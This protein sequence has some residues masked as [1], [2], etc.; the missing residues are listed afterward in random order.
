MNEVSEELWQKGSKL[1]LNGTSL[2]S[3]GPRISV[4]GVAPKYLSKAVGSVFWSVDD[5]KYIDYGMAVGSVIL[6]H[7]VI[8]QDVFQLMSEYGPNATILNPLQVELAERLYKNIRGCEKMKFL[9]SGSEATESAVRMARIATGRDKI[10]HD[11]YHGWMS[12]SVPG[13][14]GVPKCYKDLS[15]QKEDED[16]EWFEKQ[17]KKEDVAGV[18]LEPVKIEVESMVDRAKYLKELK[19][20]CSKY[21]T[22]LIFDEVACGYR[23]GLGGAQGV[24]GVMPDISAFGKSI[25]NGY[26]LSVVCCTS[27][28]AEKVE[29]KLFVSSTF[30]GNP[31]ALSAGLI[32]M[33]W[34]EKYDVLQKIVDGGL[35]LKEIEKTLS[36][37]GVKI[38]GTPYRIGWK[39]DDWD[40]YSYIIQEFLRRKIFFG[41]EIKN[42]ATH[43]YEQHQLAI[44]TGIS[45]G[46]GVREAQRRN[47]NIK[48]LIRGKPIRPIL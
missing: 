38:L 17:L 7:G 28:I 31:L 8:D 25:S 40:L 36:L 4:D 12:W 42:S 32:T 24:L 48:D 19:E 22:T 27:E 20:I 46:S 41:W 44:E 37:E 26:P 39:C 23:F 11:H 29:D 2:F 47:K 14:A 43:T 1:V 21:G 30:G 34:F 9:S 13:G 35:Q 10:I 15:I 16:L 33:D 45:I 6:G 3:R 5:E 18:I